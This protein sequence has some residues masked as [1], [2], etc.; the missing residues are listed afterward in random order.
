MKAPVPFRRIVGASSAVLAIVALVWVFQVLV[1]RVPIGVGLK[2]Q[3]MHRK[4]MA[5]QTILDGMIRGDLQRVEKAA[6]QLVGYRDTI[7][8]FI[9]S[10]EYEKHG[11]DF[12]KSVDDVID[13]AARKDLNSAKEATLRLERSCIECHLLMNQR[14]TQGTGP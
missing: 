12:R 6:N 5:M 4:T 13:A 14:E 7:A 11:E 2:A 3:M 10:A 1:S 8:Q 9:S